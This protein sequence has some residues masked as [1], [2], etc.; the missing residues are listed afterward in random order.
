MDWSEQR[1]LNMSTTRGSIDRV[2][3]TSWSADPEAPT[4]ADDEQLVIEQAIE[5]IEHTTPGNHVNPV[6]H[7]EQGHLAV[8]LHAVLDER[9]RDALPT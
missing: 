6:T 2:H 9:F 1:H 3:D 7:G 5:A 8:Y 4:H